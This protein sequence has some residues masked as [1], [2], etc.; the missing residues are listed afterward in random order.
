MERTE[1]YSKEAVLAM[2]CTGIR[3]KC[4]N[5]TDRPTR[6]RFSVWHGNVL[7]LSGKDRFPCETFVLGYAAALAEFGK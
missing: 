2:G 1:R 5:P 7:L 4:D 6:Q 3:I